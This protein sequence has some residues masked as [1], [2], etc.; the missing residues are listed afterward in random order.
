MESLFDKNT[1]Q[2]FV[3]RIN[4][5]SPETNALW[6]KMRVE[7][8]LWH[9]QKPFEIASGALR[10]KVNPLL[11]LIFGKSA[12]KGMTGD[13]PVKKNLPTFKEAKA[14]NAVVF[15]KEKKNLITLIENFQQKGVEGL[16]K[17][18]HPFFGNMSVAEWNAL[19]IK[20]LDH[21]LKQFGV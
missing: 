4:Q 15:E 3:E 12:K 1:V 13:I 11:K 16:T 9:C 19:E 6:G 2:K 14:I 7:Q 5:L 10:P 8:M 17:K 21:H 20:H 18:P